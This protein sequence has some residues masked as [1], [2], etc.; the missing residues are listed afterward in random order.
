VKETCERCRKKKRKVSDVAAAN[1]L[2]NCEQTVLSW[3][4]SWM[5]AAMATMWQWPAN[6]STHVLQPQKS[7]VTNSGQTRGR[8]VERVC[9]RWMETPP[10]V[11][12]RYT[13][14]VTN[15]IRRGWA[16]KAAIDKHCQLVFN[17]LPHLQPA[18]LLCVRRPPIIW[19]AVAFGV[20]FRV[21]RSSVC[22]DVK[23]VQIKIMIRQKT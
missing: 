20:C 23:N 11:K 8:H 3:V 7:A 21:V 17:P 14:E 19:R 13:L 10:I 6:C 4:V 2:D 5:S 16:M 15:E 18:I 9:Q 1:S 12:V 22:I